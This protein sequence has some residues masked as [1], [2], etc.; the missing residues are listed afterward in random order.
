MEISKPGGFLLAIMEKIPERDKRGMA[1]IEDIENKIKLLNQRGVVT[2]RFQRGFNNDFASEEF[3]D[4]LRIFEDIGWI[5][6]D[7]SNP[8]CKLTERGKRV[9]KEIDIPE[10]I[11]EKFN[12]IFE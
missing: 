7:F 1:K 12:S 5:E 3:Y 2:Y 8:H 10:L 6:I 11:K 4:D 9:V